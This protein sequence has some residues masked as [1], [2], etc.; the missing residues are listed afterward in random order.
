MGKLLVIS[1]FVISTITTA[2]GQG[3]NTKMQFY[4]DWDFAAKKCI[5]V[6]EKPT[7][8]NMVNN[9]P[10]NTRAEAETA[11]KTFKGC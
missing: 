5:I 4:I 8:P 9:G 1:A 10:F 11:I 3:T 2:S 6:S 7:N